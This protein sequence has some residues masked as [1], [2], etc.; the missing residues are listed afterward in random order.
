MKSMLSVFLLGSAVP[1]IAGD[2]RYDHTDDVLVVASFLAE[3]RSAS[4]SDERP[5]IN[6]I[7]RGSRSVSDFASFRAYANDCELE[8]IE[9]IPSASR[10][11]PLSVK[12]DCGRFEQVDGNLVW[13]ERHAAIWVSSG[14][15]VKIAFGPI[16]VISLERETPNG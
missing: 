7:D 12:W 6:F 10:P 11:L 13:E 1:A 16:P 9:A 15:I 4:T 2:D 8:N 14:V 3:T 5:M